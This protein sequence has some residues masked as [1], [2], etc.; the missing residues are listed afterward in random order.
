[1]L[2]KQ[3]SKD[4]KDH[5]DVESDSKTILKKARVLKIIKIAPSK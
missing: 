1:M 3:I 5:V 4:G 2:L